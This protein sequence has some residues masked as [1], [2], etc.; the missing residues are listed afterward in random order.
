MMRIVK[1]QLLVPVVSHWNQFG[2]PDY[3]STLAVSI[4]GETISTSAFMPHQGFK[5]LGVD[6]LEIARRGLR[7]DLMEFIR[8]ELF[9]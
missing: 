4:G 5:L 7:S 8:R 3:E 1:E 9:K 2:L 6:A